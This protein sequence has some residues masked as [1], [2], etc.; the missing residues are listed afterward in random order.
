MP[1]IILGQLVLQCQSN[2][3]FPDALDQDATA[4]ARKAARPSAG[5]PRCSLAVNP[6]KAV[7]W[8]IKFTLPSSR[9]TAW[10]HLILYMYTV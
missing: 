6:L 10:A 1:G 4:W 5:L 9:L 2:R 3:G 7:G 8:V